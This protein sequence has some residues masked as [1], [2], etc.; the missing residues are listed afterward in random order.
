MLGLSLTIA[1]CATD[2]GIDDPL[3]SEAASS[4]SAAAW[5]N[6]AQAGETYYNA[7]VASI[8][9][10]TI[11][12]AVGDNTG[13][14]YDGNHTNL[15]WRKMTTN[16]SWTTWSRI[17]GQ[18]ASSKV[19]LAAFNGYIYMV[20]TGGDDSSATWYSRF[21]PNSETWSQNSQIPAY[22]SYNGPPAIVAYNNLLYFIASQ[23]NGVMWVAT[24][25]PGEGFSA[26]IGINHHT[27]TGRPSAAVLNGKLYIAHTLLAPNDTTLV[28]GTFD[29]TTWSYPLHI[30]NG[31]AADIYG[32]EAAIATD[33]GVLQ[34]VHTI[35]TGD[36]EPVYWTY[37]DGCN[38]AGAEVTLADWRTS[39]APA[40]TQGGPGL[41]MTTTSD[42]Y[43]W[44]W[45]TLDQRNV[46]SHTY[47]HPRITRPPVVPICNIVA[48]P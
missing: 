44:F 29:G 6:E 33:Q 31:T 15:Y 2:D 21:D 42:D 23:S 37:F 35:G 12:V 25:T 3:T 11:Q 30:K 26:P 45:Q 4:L 40:L 14:V 27:S 9:G 5:G 10:K 46:I 43:D 32:R 39:Q 16:A 34:L 47:T 20:H 36:S 22:P 24:M 7:A 1:A 18:E 13:L 8:N 28:Y 48:Q 19:S 17:T 38:W 41:V